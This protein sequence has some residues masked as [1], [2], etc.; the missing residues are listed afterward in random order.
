[1]IR[2]AITYE[3]DKGR[4]LMLA[5]IT[6]PSLLVE[7]AR[8]ALAEAEMRCDILAEADEGLAFVQREELE[9]L[10]R[11]LTLFVPGLKTEKRMAVPGLFDETTEDDH[12]PVLAPV[13]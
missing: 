12:A 2:L 9:R 3:P 6:D 8:R 7:A 1:M 4:P 5:S 13:A 11:V 10:R